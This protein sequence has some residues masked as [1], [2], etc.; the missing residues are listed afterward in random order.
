LTSDGYW[1]RR[2]RRQSVLGADLVLVGIIS[3]LA[4][5]LGFTLGMRGSCGLAMLVLAFFVVCG[6][7]KLARFNVTAVRARKTQAEVK[8]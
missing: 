7:S 6:I 1:A 5:V 8:Y 3:G 2:S 4:A